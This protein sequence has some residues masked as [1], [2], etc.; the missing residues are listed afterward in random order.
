LTHDLTHRLKVLKIPP[1]FIAIVIHAIE[2]WVVPPGKTGGSSIEDKV[3]HA[4][5][6][7]FRDGLEVA[8][9]AS[10]AALI[11]VAVVAAASLRG[12]NTDQI[13]PPPGRPTAS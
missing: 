4:A 7:A 12:G 13:E 5:Y 8:L 2:T 3:I 10:G 9:L 11:A 6:A 1:N